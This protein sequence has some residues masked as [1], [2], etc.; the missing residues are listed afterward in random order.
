MKTRNLAIAIAL[1]GLIVTG[2]LIAQSNTNTNST[3]T[4]T[5]YEW[6]MISQHVAG[7]G[8][9]GA[10]Q[11]S[12]SS[13]GAPVHGNVFLFNKRTGKVYRFWAGC[14]D[15]GPNGCLEP[16]PTVTLSATYT[17]V[18]TSSGGSSTFQPN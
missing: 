10:G 7:T 9:S 8:G 3:D 18:P 16:L 15:D 13:A 5:E 12:E 17:V 6:D 11:A 1:G 2:V 14:Q 4:E